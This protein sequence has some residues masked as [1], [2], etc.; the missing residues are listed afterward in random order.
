VLLPS[1]SAQAADPFTDLLLADAVLNQR[2]LG[3]HIDGLLEDVVDVPVHALPILRLPI[4]LIKSAF[5]F[6]LPGVPMSMGYDD[7]AA[8]LS[9]PID[10]VAAILKV[11]VNVLRRF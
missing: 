7:I 3:G 4:G 11:P 10:T 6:L 8:G 2:N 9:A 5:G 1:I